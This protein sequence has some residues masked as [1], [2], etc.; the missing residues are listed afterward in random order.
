MEVPTSATL[1][2]D[3]LLPELTDKTWTWS[4]ISVAACREKVI[5]SL[6]LG[7]A[8]LTLGFAPWRCSGLSSPRFVAAVGRLGSFRE[9]WKPTLEDNAPLALTLREGVICVR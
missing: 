9:N 4:A 6:R 2:S 5:G 8:P 7:S 1:K 3:G